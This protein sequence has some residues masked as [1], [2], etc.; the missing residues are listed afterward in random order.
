MQMQLLLYY[1]I[2]VTGSFPA[3]RSES[4]V[5]DSSLTHFFHTRIQIK[6]SGMAICH[7][8]SLLWCHGWLVV[9]R[10]ARCILDLL[11]RRETITEMH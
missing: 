10:Q 3:T 5:T 7:F 6:A 1:F 4:P 2:F 11:I 9:H 8:Y